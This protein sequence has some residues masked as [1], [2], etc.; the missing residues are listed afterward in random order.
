M[1]R[2]SLVG[3]RE[4]DGWMFREDGRWC[5][6]PLPVYGE[7]APLSDEQRLFFVGDW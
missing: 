2:I 3:G 7:V 1:R 6:V 5:D 4:E